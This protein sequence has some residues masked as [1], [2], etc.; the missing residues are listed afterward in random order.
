MPTGPKS[1]HSSAQTGD[2]RFVFTAPIHSPTV[3]P[4]SDGL[5]SHRERGTANSSEPVSW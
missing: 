5:S 3:T 4:V 1:I 2:D